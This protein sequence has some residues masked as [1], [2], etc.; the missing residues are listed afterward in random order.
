MKAPALSHP[1]Q[2]ATKFARC[3]PIRRPA[4]KNSPNSGLILTKPRKSSPSKPKNT[5]NRPFL[6]SRANFFAF[7][8]P[9][10]PAGRT[11][12][13]RS[14]TQQ[15]IH[16]RLQPGTHDKARILRQQEGD[17]SLSTD[18]LPRPKLSTSSRSELEPHPPTAHSGTHAPT[19][20]FASPSRRSRHVA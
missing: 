1:A 20:R 15:P 2:T 7:P 19:K 4:R 9:L 17:R 8:N 3:A 12:S 5:E 10:H 11:F 18:H 6:P 16:A 13:R 14:N